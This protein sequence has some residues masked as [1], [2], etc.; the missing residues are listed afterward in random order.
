MSNKQIGIIGLGIMGKNLTLNFERNGYQVSIF[1]RTKDKINELIIQHPKKNIKPFYTIKK[2]INS[3]NNPKCILLMVKSGKATDETIKKII[4]LLKKED[5]LIDGGNTFY[6]DTI[7]RYKKLKKIGIN[8]I[9]MGISGG[10]SGALNGPSLMPG[11]DKKTYN[12]ISH[13]LKKISAKKNNEPCVDYIGPSGS[14]H[15]IKMVHNGIEYGNMQLISEIYNIFKNLLLMNNEEISNIFKKWNKKKLNS[16]LIKITSKILKFK[17]K[18]NQYLIDFIID[19]GDNKGTGKW[20]SISA[21]ELELPF[22]LITEAVFCRYL[23]NFKKERQMASK[24]IEK[25]NVKNIKINKEKFIKHLE[26]ALYFGII[27][28]YTQGFTLIKQASKKHKWNLNHSII[29]K[30]FQE[31]CIIKAKILN[32]IML[33]YKKNNKIKNLL[34]SPIFQ[35]KTK[36]YQLSIRKILIKSIKYNLAVPT[37]SSSLSYYDS[38]HS[39]KLPINLIQAQRDYFG[40]HM[41]ERIDKNG[42]FHTNWIL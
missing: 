2:F 15:Y 34:L 5:I 6:K 36:K 42:K 37:L 32:E 29:A 30:I 21:L 28:S 1:N 16:Y 22:S 27:I 39:E 4:P 20:A 10:G 38:Y 24:N 11:G 3:L 23:S 14:G 33:I 19:K 9:D 35:K 40:N 31:G 17:N 25:T 8:F 26:H 41:Y 18:N 7:K 12:K 13:F